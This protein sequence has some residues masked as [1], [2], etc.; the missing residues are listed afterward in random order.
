G[1]LCRPSRL[2]PLGIALR[3]RPSAA[4]VR[5]AGVLLWLCHRQHGRPRCSFGRRGTLPTIHGH[6]A[7]TRSDRPRHPLHLRGFRRGLAAIAALGLALR[8]DEVSSLLGASP[9]PLRAVAASVLVSAVVFLT[10]CAVRRTPLRRGPI[11][12]VPPGAT[13]VLTQIGLSALDIL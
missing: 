11:E 2:R 6:R 7:F 10:L 4:E 12:L 1:E 8:A 3:G 9:E 13:L 5:A